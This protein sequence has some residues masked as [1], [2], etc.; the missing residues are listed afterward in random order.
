MT[1]IIPFYDPTK[2]YYQNCTDGPFGGFADSKKYQNKNNTKYKFFDYNVNIPFGIPAGPLP[3]A[4]FIKAAFEKGFDIPIYKTV[5]TKTHPC[6]KF[7]NVIPV[8][9]QGDLTLEKAAAG[10]IMDDDFKDPI[11]TTNSFGVPSLDP[12]YWQPDMKKSVESAGDGQIMVASFQGTNRGKGV[13]AF[14]E[15]CVLGAQLCME[16]GAKVL[17][18]NLSCPNEGKKT[19]LCHD[20]NLVEK[21]SDKVKNKI[22]NI[23]LI[24]KLAYF[25]DQSI[26]VDFISRLAKI[27]D[28]FAAINTIAAEV[29]KPNGEQ[30]LPGEGRLVSGICGYPIRWAGV[31]MATRLKKIRESISEDFII[32]GVGGVTNFSEFNQYITVGADI[33]MSATGAMWNPDLAKKINENI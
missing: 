15:D 13:E 12:E 5:R 10:V 2:T 3:N 14:V 30:A 11:A 28:G 29:R 7:P 16:T 18:M 24:L 19:L 26:L 25:T 8:K 32:I 17:E 33:V 31:E 1:K 20:T 23:P 21:I 4:K 22:G 6:N 9:I 27:V